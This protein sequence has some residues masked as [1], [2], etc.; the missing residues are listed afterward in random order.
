MTAKQILE[1]IES[2][3]PGDTAKL[4][5][6]DALVEMYLKDT[7]TDILPFHIYNQWEDSQWTRSRDALKAIRPD[8]WVVQVRTIERPTSWSYVA[9]AMNPKLRGAKQSAILLTEELAELHAIIQAIDY[10][11]TQGGE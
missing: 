2:V 3:E 9:E 5:E 11:R 10:D 6:I 7:S 8:G 1:M 4:D